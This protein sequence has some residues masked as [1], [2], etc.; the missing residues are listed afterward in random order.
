M[1]GVINVVFSRLMCDV[2]KAEFTNAVHLTGDLTS[3]KQSS[4]S[5]SSPCSS[6]SSSSSWSSSSLANKF[7]TFELNI[8]I[9][10][11]NT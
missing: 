3:S 9:K 2:R 10:G 8:L 4:S 1:C 11:L 7:T 5:S 6:S